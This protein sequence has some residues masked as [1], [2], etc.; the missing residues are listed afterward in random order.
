MRERVAPW[1][2]GRAP[3]S[4]GPAAAT[5]VGARL[6]WRDPALWV[7]R[8]AGQPTAHVRT[9]ERGGARLAVLGPCSASERELARAL[10]S[11]DLGEAI[12][13]WAG[14]H[15]VVRMDG[16][17]IVEVLA[18][19]AGASPLYVVD[20]PGGPVWGSSSLALSS[21]TGAKVDAEWL[22]ARLRDPFS[23]LPGHSAWAGV[24]P[25]PPGHVLTLGAPGAGL[26]PWWRAVRRT[27]EEV[28][29]RLRRVL[30]EGVRVRVEGVSATADLAGMDSTTI[31]LLAAR[32]GPVTGVTLHPEG[33]T[34]GGDLEYARALSVPGLDQRFLPLGTRHLPFAPS[35]VPLP[36]TDEPATSTAT[37]SMF[38]DQLRMIA[39]TGSGC[40]LTGD[41]GDA[42][43]LAAPTHLAALVRRGRWL[44]M[45]GDAMEWA[46]LRRQDPRPLIAAA[47]RGDAGRIGRAPRPRPPWLAAP[48]P[49][50]SPPAGTAAH[51]VFVASLRNAAR[52]AHSEIQLAAALGVGLANPYFDGAVLDAVVSAPAGQRYSARRYKPLLAD[53]FAEL[54]PE[55]HRERATKGVFAGD[56]HQGLRR[57]LRRVLALTDGRLAAGGIIAP[58]PLREA[59]HSA[60]LGAPTVWPPLLAALAAEAWLEAVE[61]APVTRWEAA[62]PPPGDVR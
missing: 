48:V 49:E 55:A 18:D 28:A 27:P 7:V 47:L 1:Y 38:S 26:S 8:D 33:V 56:F 17:G 40:H 45:L 59:L 30:A 61:N 25:V 19:T 54:L 16:S 60:A 52:T 41:G 9:V 10:S 11:L 5:P 23:P 34:R 24:R 51:P 12:G 13:S 43:F 31:T 53:T 21:L 32:Y 2:G 6:L 46:R 3:G 14:T 50:V 22:A 4:R 15:T 58:G 36:A 62:A 29:R 37:W 57:H 39:E 20:T 35:D 42:L 44:R